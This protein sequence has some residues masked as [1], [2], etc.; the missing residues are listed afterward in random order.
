MIDVCGKLDVC[1]I[2]E[3]VHFT[4]ASGKKHDAET[5]YSNYK[6]EV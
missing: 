5:F 1:C 2:S 4:G 6:E 3:V